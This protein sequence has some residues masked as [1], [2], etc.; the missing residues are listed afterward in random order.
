MQKTINKD[1][2]EISKESN[3]G[4]NIDRRKSKEGFYFLKAMGSSIV[5]IK[6]CPAEVGGLASV[7]KKSATKIAKLQTHNTNSDIQR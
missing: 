2:N 1:F 3:C 6:A 5:D 7:L 4:L